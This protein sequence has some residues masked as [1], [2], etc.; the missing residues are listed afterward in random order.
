[1]P[2]SESPATC[3]R[4]APTSSSRATR[5][6]TRS[7]SVYGPGRRRGLPVPAGV[8]GDHAVPLGQRPAPAGPTSPRV[9]PEGVG[10]DD[11][12]RVRRPVHGV[13]DG[14]G[15]HAVPSVSRAWSARTAST[16]APASPV[17][18]AASSSAVDVDVGPPGEHLA[19]RPAGRPAPPGWPAP[20]RRG[21]RRAPSVGASAS[22][23]APAS[24]GSRAAATV[25]AMRAVSGRRP[26]EALGQP[27]GGRPDGRQ[28]RGQRGPLAVPGAGGALVLLLHRAEQGADQAGGAAGAGSGGDRR[29]RVGLV[30]HRRGAA[31]RRRPR[32]PRRPRSAPS[33]RRRR[34]SWRPPRRPRPGRRRGRRSAAA[35][36][37]RATGCR[38][39]PAPRR[40]PSAAR[41]RSR[42]SRPACRRR[43]RTA[44]A[45]R[46]PPRPAGAGRPSRPASQPAAFSPNVV[47]SA[48]CISVRPMTTSSRWAAAS[49][50]A[51]ARP[52]RPG[53]RR[54]RRSRSRASSTS[55][56]S[57]MSWLVAPTCTAT[58][59]PLAD[60]VLQHAHQRRHR[61]AG[62]RG[63]RHDGREVQPGRGPRQAGGHRV[64][65]RRR[66]E[67]HAGGR[68]GER[69]LA[70]RAA[71]GT[72]RRRR[73]RRPLPR[74][75][76]CRRR[77]RVMRASRSQD[78]SYREEHRL[79]V[80]LQ[81]EVEPVAVVGRRGEQGRRGV[82]P[83]ATAGRRPRR[84]PRPR[85]R[86][87]CG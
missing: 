20:P 36:C 85:R 31:P 76:R 4:C 19:Q 18:G 78:S 23:S 77:V 63:P 1:M 55:A 59:S 13:G 41:R 21:P 35:R 2:P 79:A 47:G 7:S 27:G 58:A 50:A 80:T 34:R 12:G 69:G 26:V 66:H 43:R 37:A 17:S 48:C 24:S 29:D 45:A 8:V 49:R 70:P 84:W 53:R 15:T 87:R 73:R 38:P 32:S 64:G 44:P 65:R 56:V 68:P 46:P 14:D 67:A 61:V 11:D 16:C 3:A 25:A 60:G 22:A 81:V 82:R 83:A 6:S 51:D 52:R 40:T 30:R 33:A 57:R 9:A 71:P 72:T 5:S 10:E 39:G 62:V 74:A 75:R 42:R 28:Q 86:S 54:S